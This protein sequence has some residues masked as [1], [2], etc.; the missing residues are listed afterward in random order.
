M[1]V[2]DPLENAAAWHSGSGP[3]EVFVKRFVAPGEENDLH[4]TL[5]LAEFAHQSLWL[6]FAR[7]AKIDQKHRRI[8]IHVQPCARGSLIKMQCKSAVHR[9]S[10]LANSF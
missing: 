3:Q 5:N 10:A 9:H 6:T 4:T 1:Q 7:A 2:I 8:C